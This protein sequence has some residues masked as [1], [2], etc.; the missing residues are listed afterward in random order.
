VTDWAEVTAAALLGTARRSVD[1]AGL[2]GA[3]GAA[4]GRTADPDPAVRLLEAAALAAPYRRAG[5]RPDVPARPVPAPAGTDGLRPLRPAG[6]GHLVRVLAEPTP[7]LLLEWA[8]AAA[9]G[10]WRPPADLLPAL[11]DA[12]ARD[13]A[14]GA[15]VRPVLGARG[16]WLA[17]ARP[18]WAALADPATDPAAATEAADSSVWEHGSVGERR[19]LF[20]ADPARGR[21]LLAGT[22]VGESGPDREWFLDRIAAAPVDADEPLL[23]AALDDRRKG[24][25]ERAAGALALLPRSAYGARMAARAR[26]A[27]TVERRLLRTRLA[28]TP[29]AELD[30]G[31]TRDGIRP[32]PPT[33]TGPQ[34]W[35][36]RQ[37]VAATPL[38]AWADLGPPADLLGWPA[39]EWRDV[40]L[41]GWREAA[42]RQRDP[43]W[44]TALLGAGAADR[45]L[46]A[47]VGAL[48]ADRRAAAAVGVLRR[49]PPPNAWLLATVLD[50]CPG[51]W[52][53]E[54]AGA[55]LARLVPGT[56]PRDARDVLTLLGHR[57]PPDRAAA[58]RDRAAA[59][60]G[61]DW[62]P[63]LDAVADTL[64]FRH[65]LLEELR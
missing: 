9:A 64:A 2:P 39:G 63:A 31:M 27:V 13:R 56:R 55:V 51:P 6:I 26:A 4:A 35:W 28:V 60:R 32:T 17:A 46:P 11:L 24:V 58:V 47:L 61:T 50:A 21:V 23:E 25:R 36:L 45:D 65:A 43:A 8:A 42:L 19:A 15:A 16:R 22:W 7:V 14:V 30:A 12:G 52:P 62:G 1:V 37:V 49:S 40:L 29:P 57:L 10:G 38:A 44:V 20:D 48:P 41:A 18:D 59:A 3:L 34:A 54:L 5:L 53:D 33:G